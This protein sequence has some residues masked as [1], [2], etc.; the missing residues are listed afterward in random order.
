L[1]TL[2]LITIYRRKRA[3]KSR[4]FTKYP[5]PTR[6]RGFNAPAENFF[7]ILKSECINRQKIKDFAMAKSLID[8]YIYFYNNERIQIKTKLTPLEQRRQ[9]G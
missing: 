7:G 6:L 8:E 5:N 9:Y 3:K 2:G 4:C 1:R